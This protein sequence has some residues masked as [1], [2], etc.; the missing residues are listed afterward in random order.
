L[1]KR[2]VANEVDA[3]MKQQYTDYEDLMRRKRQENIDN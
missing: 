3:E 1:Q 2:T